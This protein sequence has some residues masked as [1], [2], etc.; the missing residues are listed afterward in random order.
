MDPLA[1]MESNSPAGGETNI[2]KARA[3]EDAGVMGATDATQGIDER[4][5]AR[6]LTAADVE[7]CNERAGP[8]IRSRWAPSRPSRRL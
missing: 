8:F 2:S 1:D 5:V 7:A 3:E 6:W 4:L